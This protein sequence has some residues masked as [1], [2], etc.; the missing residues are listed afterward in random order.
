MYSDLEIL[1]DVRQHFVKNFDHA[2]DWARSAAPHGGCLFIFALDKYQIRLFECDSDLKVTPM[3]TINLFPQYFWRQMYSKEYCTS[4]L[5][6]LE[7]KIAELEEME[8]APLEN[9]KVPHQLIGSSFE[10]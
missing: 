5:Q 8:C 3:R 2:K 1:R 6:T 9:P 10:A 4:L 7:R